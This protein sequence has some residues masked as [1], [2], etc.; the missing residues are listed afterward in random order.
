MFPAAGAATT[1]INNVYKRY[2]APRNEPRV[3]FLIRDT[4]VSH[5]L[6]TLYSPNGLA[7]AIRLQLPNSPQRTIACVYSTFSRQ[8]KKEGDLFAQSLQPYDII[9]GDCNDDIWSSDPTS[10]WQQDLANSVLLDPLHASSQ[11]PEPRHYYTHIPRHGRP[12]RLDAILIRQQITNI[13]WTYYDTIQM[14]ISDHALVL[15]GIRLEDR[16]P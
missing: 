11:P 12:L 10:P 8:D 3:A 5:V 14:P 4:V 2:A 1:A 6:E 7:G 15:L 16:S 9:M 13:P